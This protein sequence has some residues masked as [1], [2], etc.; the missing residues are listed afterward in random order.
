MST[1]NT[2]SSGFT[3]GNNTYDKLK[4]LVMIVLPALAALYIALAAFWGFPKVEEVAGSITALATFLGV[5]LGI[6]SKNYDPES[7]Q[8]VIGDFVVSTTPSGK[9]I[10]LE[11]SRDPVDYVEGDLL[12]FRLK[13]GVMDEE[14][15]QNYR[16]DE[17]L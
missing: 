10:T 12:T 16:G 5:L 3:F 11:L 6:S 2:P 13:E 7:N 14:Q 1:E 9:A 4:F 17:V 8:E 15:M